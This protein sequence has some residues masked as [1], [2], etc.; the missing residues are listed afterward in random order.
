MVTAEQPINAAVIPHQKP[1][2]TESATISATT[3]TAIRTTWTTLIVFVTPSFPAPSTLLLR[4]QLRYLAKGEL[5]RRFPPED[6]DQ[7]L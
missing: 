6:R 5:D 2:S 3:A 1:S 7:D 4:L